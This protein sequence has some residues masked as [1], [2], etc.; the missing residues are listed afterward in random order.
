MTAHA[1]PPLAG[2]HVLVTRAGEQAK[3]M[4]ARLENLGATVVWV[5]T[6]A[7]VPVDSAPLDAAIA[8]FD[9]YD[10]MVFTSANA[11]SVF[12]DRLSAASVTL[13]AFDGVRVCAIGSATAHRLRESGIAVDLIPQQFIAESIVVELVA[14][15]MAGK[16]IL[17]PQADIARKTIANGLRKAGATVDV[18]VAYRTQVP[19]GVDSDTI[20]R[21]LADIDIAIFA[22]PSAVRN[23]MTLAGGVVPEMQIVCIGPVTASA[24]RA[25]GLTVAA[26]ADEFSADGL[27]DAVLHVVAAREQGGSR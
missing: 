13:N 22:S 10:W 25:L 11:V 19:D 20:R 21:T 26:V 15:G 7:I 14:L 1:A 18:V 6:I 2:K 3:S 16:R 5:P 8:R 27:I 17:L 23:L 12:V 4:T 9:C 24:A